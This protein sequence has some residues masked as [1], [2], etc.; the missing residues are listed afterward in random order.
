VNSFTQTDAT[1]TAETLSE[2]FS[3]TTGFSWDV[4]LAGSGLKSANQFTWT[5][6]ESTGSVNG[7]SHQMA[8]SLSSGT[9]G[10]Y[11]YVPI[12]MDTVYHTFVFQTE[13]GNNSCP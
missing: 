13:A 3:F 11:G 7:S 6:S 10:C 12:F 1:Q 5:D 4:T 9:V 8:V 2:S